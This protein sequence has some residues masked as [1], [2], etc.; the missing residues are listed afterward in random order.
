MSKNKISGHVGMQSVTS[1]ISITLVLILLGLIAFIVLS[2]KNLSV[3]VRENI[4]FSI[5]FTDST[6]DADA[7]AYW[8]QLKKAPYVKSANYISRQ[9]ALKEANETLGTNPTDFLGY[10]PYT[11]TIEVKLK[12]AY[13]NS[14][15]IDVIEK[16]IKHRPDIEDISY[17]KD[18][19]NS[20]NSNIRNISLVLLGLAV[21]LTIISFVLINN[22][23]RLSIYSKRFIIYTMK[24]VGANWDFIR[25]PF[26]LR[27]LWIGIV[28]AVVANGALFG[29]IYWLVNYE[30][31]LLNIITPEILIIVGCIVT[32][33]GIF[34]TVA[35]AFFSLNKYLRMKA[36]ALYNM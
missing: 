4:G 6:T 1:G 33:F 25:K 34:I 15:S 18:L 31:E 16:Q 5:A 12:S 11:P 10:N 13:A 28:A 3:Y 30:Q 26:I 27:N 7:M 32:F 24:L 2:A 21:L 8:Q 36:D 19:V 29:G 20:I 22:T 35:C 23:I 9:Q 17:Q 14:D